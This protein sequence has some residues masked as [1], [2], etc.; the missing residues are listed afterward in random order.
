[1]TDII[2]IVIICD[3]SM[4]C[5]VNGHFQINGA[6]KARYSM[7]VLAFKKLLRPI[8]RLSAKMTGLLE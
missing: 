2:Y 8:C 7:V 1:M 3:K 4:A 5:D 6:M